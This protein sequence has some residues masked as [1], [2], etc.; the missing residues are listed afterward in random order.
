MINKDKFEDLDKEFY[1]NRAN[2]LA[3]SAVT[4][5]GITESAIDPDVIKK[6]RHSFS[7]ELKQGDITDQKQ[8][9]RCWMF[10]ALNTMR[11]RI[12]H[13]LN[14]ETFELSQA[15]PLFFDKLEKSN[16]FLESI[17]KTVDEDL[18]GRLV[19]H[20][21]AD[22]LG[23]GGQW[24]MFVNLIE[25]YGVVPKY[26]MPEVNLSSATR[27]MDNY[28][29]KM[30]RFFAKELR[31]AH[32]AGKSLEELNKMK[33]SFNED[34][35][36]A[37]TISLGTPP[38]R[39]DFEARDKDDKY[40]CE[41][42]LTPKE[43]FDKY[44]KMNLDDFVSL[45]NAPT[46]DKPYNQTF[47]VDFLGNVSE[48]KPVKYLNLEINKLKEA[49]IRQLKDNKPVWMGC[50]VG[51]SFIRKEG[52]LDI[53]AFRIRDLFDLDFTMSKAERLDYSE[54]LMTHAMVFTGVDLDEEGKPIRWKI[55]NSW[56][57]RAGNKGYL[58]MSDGW[59]DQY[60]YQ[61]AVE[62]KYLT[63]EEKKDWEKDPI[64]LKPWDPMGS[65]AK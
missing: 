20:L 38:K 44:V 53:E 45:I 51:Q 7:I 57:E 40:I 30:L 13:D 9:G 59:F 1:K 58:V 14:L 19:K 29:T 47:T 24:D 23:D 25:K 50:D 48:G 2:I 15:Y 11:Y 37:L 33:D 43:F 26:A 62:K 36:R 8:S 39:I 5:N 63:E 65:L 6:S 28:L 17:I 3:Q 18:Q 54:S 12:I 49:A 60:M 64:H 52:V 32:K 22:P 42:N 4:R 16:Y 56:G 55:E 34:I 41:K 61:I 31:S 35:Y 46:E 27:E 10:S 21:L